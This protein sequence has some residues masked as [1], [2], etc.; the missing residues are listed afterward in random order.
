[1][2]AKPALIKTKVSL[3]KS[4]HLIL[5]TYLVDLPRIGLGSGQCECPVLPL[6]HKPAY[7]LILK[8]S[9]GRLKCA[10]DTLLSRIYKHEPVLPR[11]PFVSAHSRP[12]RDADA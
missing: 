2:D 12:R 11:P 6:N 1:M 3:V 4:R 9:S 8:S 5:N 7:Y 10:C